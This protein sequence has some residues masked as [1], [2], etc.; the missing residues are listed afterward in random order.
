M[1]EAEP[2]G[3]GTD[4]HRSRSGCNVE[5]P[6]LRKLPSVALLALGLGLGV[7]EHPAQGASYAGGASNRIC[8]VSQECCGHTQYQQQRQTVLQ[9]VQETVYDQQEVPVVRTVYETVLA[10]AD[11]HHRQECRRA[12][13]ARRAVH[14]PAARLSHGSAGGSLHRPAAGHPD[15]LEGRDLHGHPSGA[16]RRTWSRGRTRSRPRCAKPRSRP[17]PTTSATRCARSLTRT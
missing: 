13:R 16:A 7:V 10:A 8:P 5:R 14:D 3:T 11:C 1:R 12:A 4:V 2:L 15:R 9:N 6:M 17:A